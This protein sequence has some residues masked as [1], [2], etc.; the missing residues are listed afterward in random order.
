MVSFFG[1]LMLTG[2]AV[3]LHLASDRRPALP[4]I[5]T[6]LV[7]YLA[8]VVVTLAVNVPL[9][10]ALKRAGDPDRIA[11]AVQRSPVGRLEPRAH[12]A[13]DGGVRLPRLG[14]RVCE[15]GGE[16]LKLG[17]VVLLSEDAQ[18]APISELTWARNTVPAP[19]R[20]AVRGGAADAWWA[21]GPEG[22]RH[23][24]RYEG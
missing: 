9:N 23:E 16:L 2:V 15:R 14:P 4:S 1:A 11:D 17:P 7:L 20:M 8:T 5:L 13:V 6:A 18:S 12:V 24:S 22:A 21:H 3:A 10:N 19:V